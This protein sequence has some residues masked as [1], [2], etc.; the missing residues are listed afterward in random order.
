MG[1]ARKTLIITFAAASVVACPALFP[2]SPKIIWNASASVPTGLYRVAPMDRLQVA[3]LVLVQSQE[4]LAKLLDDGGCL[5]R[6]VPLL[7]HDDSSMTHIR[8]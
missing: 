4:A 1:V 2:Q 7:E 8:R 3:D 6:G 5:P